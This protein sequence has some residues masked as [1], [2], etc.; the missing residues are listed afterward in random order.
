[1]LFVLKTAV[2]RINERSNEDRNRPQTN[3]FNI[4]IFSIPFHLHLKEFSQK[5]CRGYIDIDKKKTGKTNKN[6][7]LPYHE[8]THRAIS[9][10]AIAKTKKI[11]RSS[12]DFLTTLARSLRYVHAYNLLDRGLLNK[13]SQSPFALAALALHIACVAAASYLRPADSLSG[14]WIE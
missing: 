8:S 5:F 14:C 10:N 7:S 3:L 4:V 6:A 12:S 1:M 9:Q 2:H 11:L 13:S